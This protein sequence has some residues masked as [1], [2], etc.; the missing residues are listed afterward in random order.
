MSSRIS[1]SVRSIPIPTR[2]PDGSRKLSP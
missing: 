2:G 1:S